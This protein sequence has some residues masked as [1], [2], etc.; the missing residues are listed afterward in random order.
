MTEENMNLTPLAIIKIKIELYTQQY[1]EQARELKQKI[2]DG[3]HIIDS[4]HGL[5]LEVRDTGQRDFSVVGVKRLLGAQAVLCIEEKVNPAKFD[6]LTKK[7]GKFMITDD[8]QK[9][10]FQRIPRPSLCWI[11]LDA[12][13]N[14]LQ[15][16]LEKKNG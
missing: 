7:G 15:R 16:A 11:G 3:T 14:N 9:E 4:E 5:E 6:A 2:L 8:Q 1:E 13:K 12:F 10:C